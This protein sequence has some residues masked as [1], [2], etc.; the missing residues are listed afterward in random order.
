MRL[1]G[2]IDVPVRRIYLTYLHVLQALLAQLKIFLRWIFSPSKTLKYPKTTE[3]TTNRAVFMGSKKGAKG[4]EV[5][6][7]LFI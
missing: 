7:L 4:F 6:K 1:V 5:I 2:L 3:S